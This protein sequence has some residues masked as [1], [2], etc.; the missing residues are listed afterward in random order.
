[1]IAIW[2]RLLILG[3][4]LMTMFRFGNPIRQAM[5]VMSSMRHFKDPQTDI[6]DVRQNDRVNAGMQAYRIA[7]LNYWPA[8]AEKFVKGGFQT[9]VR[10]V[11][12]IIPQPQ[13]LS[14]TLTG[15]W[16]QALNEALEKKARL[17]SHFALQI[18][19]N[20]P[21]L[22][23]LLHIGWLTT[24]HY[25][26]GDYLSYDFFLHAF[27][28]AAIVLFLSFFLFQGCL[29]MFSGPENI[30]RQAFRNIQKQIDPL[31]HLSGSPLFRQLELVLALGRHRNSDKQD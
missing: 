17:F 27:L 24:T 31:L 2:A 12:Q 7:V 22:G 26:V 8:I 25:V 14:E 5:G 10:Q 6:A 30:M 3:T 20:V 18:V 4:G 16:R 13:D 19:F 23:L 28:T 21:I 9:H 15:M 11:E 1:M 29:R